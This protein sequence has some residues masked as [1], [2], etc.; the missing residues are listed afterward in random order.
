M[1]ERGRTVMNTIWGIKASRF[2]RLGDRGGEVG[3]VVGGCAGRRGGGC[4]IIASSS[5][6][7]RIVARGQGGDAQ[8]DGKGL[9]L[10]GCSRSDTGV[11]SLTRRFPGNK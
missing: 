7:V 4:G 5:F 9:C 1:E 11:W 6:G 2:P 3:V 8:P 10:S